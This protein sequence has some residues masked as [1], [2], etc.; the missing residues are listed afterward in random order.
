MGTQYLF[1]T[2]L[3]FCSLIVLILYFMI[4]NQ[5]SI[6]NLIYYWLNLA[7]FTTFYGRVACAIIGF[8]QVNYGWDDYSHDLFNVAFIMFT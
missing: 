6:F 1:F 4:L 3:L 5:N 8:L 7:I 2:S